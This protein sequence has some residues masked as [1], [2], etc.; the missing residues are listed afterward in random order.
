MQINKSAFIYLLVIFVTSCSLVG[1]NM[2]RTA[3]RKPGKYPVFTKKDS[4]LGYLNPY[5]GNFDVY[6]YQL[7]IAFNVKQKTI[8]GTV[9]IYFTALKNLDTIQLNLRDNMKLNG[10]GFESANLTYTREA[11][12]VFVKFNRRIQANEKIMIRVS[13]EGKPVIA[14]KP[15]WNGGFVWKKDALKKPWVGVACEKIGANTWWPLKDHNSDEPDSALMNFTVPEGLMCVSNG[16]LNGRLVN[17]NHTETFSWKVSYPI[18]TYNITFY[19]GDFE[20]FSIPYDAEKK[21]ELNFYV[22]KDHLEIAK[23]HFKQAKKIIKFYEAVYG[24][25]AFWNDGYK[26]IESPYAGMEHQTA[27]A[28][29]N[30]FKNNEYGIDYIIL[31]ETAHEWWGNAIS[32]SDYADIWIHEGLATYSEALYIE[33]EFGYDKYIRYINFYA[34][35]IANKKP[36][37]GPRDVNYWDYNDSDPYVK[38]AL[39]LHSLRGIIHNDALFFDILKSFYSQYQ[40]KA[41]TTRDFTNLVNEKTKTNYD[42]FF[43][44]FLYNR[45][46]ARFQYRTEQD[47]IDHT[48]HMKYKWADTAPGFAMPVDIHD[49]GK[50]IR[51]WPTTEEKTY[52]I[53]N[54]ERFSIDNRA[55]YFTIDLTK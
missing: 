25:Y 41:V 33:N 5:R 24:E 22:L 4:L 37:V 15:P 28:Y 52:D 46:P 7:D 27:I 49:G 8:K 17:D 31:H 9:D 45:K 12:A 6:Y 3:A 26:L 32:V 54:A 43:N 53:G 10:I 48:Y 38:G 18:N 39:M 30:G 55:F 36:V 29:G 2:K 42:W 34:I 16:R 44:Q 14:P 51:L 11:N 23:E 40:F 35:L 20:N 50:L 47:P 19:I 1:I 21:H 13:Y